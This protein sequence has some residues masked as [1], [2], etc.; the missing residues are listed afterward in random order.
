ML[1][2]FIII[3]IRSLATQKIYSIINILGLAVGMA[4]ALLI[5]IYVV[6]ELGYDK[7]HKNTD[8]LY[9]VTVQ[10]ELKGIDTDIAVTSPPM[11]KTLMAEY[12]PVKEATRVARF[13]AWLISNNDVSFNEDEFL[14]A[15]PNFFK[16][17][18]FRFIE[19]N[20]DS[21]LVKPRSLVLTQKA[22]KK[23]FGD[24]SPVGKKLKIENEKEFYTVTGLLEDIPS[25]SHIKFEV[26]GSL[27]TFEKYLKDIWVSHNMYTY[28][29]VDRKADLKQLEEDINGLIEKYVAPQVEEYLGITYEDF[30][31]QQ[32]SLSY[33]LQSVKSI[34]LYSDL[35]NELEANGKA[36]YVYAF[37]IIAILILLIACLNFMNLSTANSA[38]RAREVILRKVIGSERRVLILQFITESILF[39]FFA[40]ALA[41]LFAEIAMPYFNRYLEIDLR[42]NVLSN[43]PSITIIVLSTF[44]LGLLA[45]SY[46]AFFISSYEPVKVLHGELNKGIKNRRIRSVFVIF[47][48]FISMLI[49]IMSLVVFAQVEF[50]LSKELGFVKERVVVIRRPDALKER[51]DDFKK[52]ILRH[53]NIESVTNSNSIPGRDF[54]SSTYIVEN[55]AKRDN[56]VMNQIFVNYDFREAFGL[57]MVEG[58]FFSSSIA[59]DSFACVLNETAARGIDI[60]SVVGSNI[61]MPGFMR[62]L[63]RSFKVIGIVK[64]FHYESV[65]KAIEPLVISLMPGNWEG[66]LIVRLSTIGI[67]KSVSFLEETWDKYETGYPFVYFFLDKD[68]DRNYK[69]V[70]R[71]GRVLFIFAI[72]SV[73]VACLGL[74]GLVSFT[75][76][77]RTREI[78]LRKAVG[79]NVYQIMYLLLKETVVLIFM[80]T[81]MAWGTAYMFSKIWLEDFN[82]RIT[83]SPSY[84]VYA[85]FIVLV[86]S[87]VVVI[88]QCI[89]ASQRQPG[90][91]LKAE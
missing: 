52:E 66:Y 23:Y 48:F 85:A 49:I 33:H 79:A 7:F 69:S 27:V 13:G 8:Q 42:F 55:N 26:L 60:D 89:T 29:L 4:S 75:T 40:L 28:I 70:I 50:M 54:I 46:P 31:G 17:F 20:P 73:F 30:L 25:N 11:A 87:V 21:A 61:E 24:E 1:K 34:H 22:A 53:P 44:L 18:S 63:G 62:K 9:R 76:N 16:L 2:N 58:R 47:Q 10:G 19:G 72:L 41:L 86:L 80:A 82:S 57:R 39:S 5:A 78:G 36:L 71:T 91:A 12:D 90:Q 81:I 88:Y 3:T 15:D 35:D 56:I 65:D 38:N 32:N 59:S 51:I 67:E 43:L 77:Q 84:F 74:F 83:L 14:F 68:F 45:G 37:S 64:D 6:H